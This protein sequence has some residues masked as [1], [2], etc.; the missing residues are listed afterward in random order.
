M[1]ESS[2]KFLI[3][4]KTKGKLP[5]LPFVEFKEKVLGKN[6]ELSMAIV[7]KSKIHFL[8]KTFRKVDSPTDI[9]SFP[10][11]DQNGEIFICQEIAKKKAPKFDKPY[12]NFLSFL[13]IH[14]LVH[15]KGYD[16][17]EEME[18]IETKYR[19]YFKI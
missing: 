12:E 5:S 16:H 11:D 4:N 18:K 13:F 3:I 10:L 8:N 2:E 7:S 6:Y 1:F 17:G 19:K 15:L 9:L 14:G